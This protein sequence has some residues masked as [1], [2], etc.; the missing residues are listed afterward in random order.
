VMGA[1]TMGYTVTPPSLL[2]RLA[3]INWP[4]TPSAE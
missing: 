2:R 1:M 3:K 4:F